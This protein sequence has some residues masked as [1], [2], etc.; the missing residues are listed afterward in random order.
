MSPVAYTLV[1]SRERLTRLSSTVET[2]SLCYQMVEMIDLTQSTIGK[3]RSV[4]HTIVRGVG[5]RP[6]NNIT[7]QAVVTGRARVRARLLHSK[8]SVIQS[9][10]VTCRTYNRV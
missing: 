2:L 10:L 8:V 6:G 9:W 4:M 1:L 7:G 5:T 3:M